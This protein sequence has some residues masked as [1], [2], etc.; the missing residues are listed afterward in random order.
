MALVGGVTCITGAAISGISSYHMATGSPLMQASSKLSSGIHAASNPELIFGAIGGIPFFILGV[1]ILLS[2]FNS[3]VSIDNVGIS[4][5]NLFGKVW[6]RAQWSEISAVQAL[7]KTQNSGYR[8]DANGKTL[9]VQT[10][11]T[12]MKDLISEVK[13]RSPN[14]KN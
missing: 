9:K 1:L 2:T 4:A 13:R 8:I 10:S 14:A 3:K 6:F 5:T 11:L 12:G 7:D